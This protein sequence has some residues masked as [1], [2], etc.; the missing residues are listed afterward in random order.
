MDT[1]VDWRTWRGLFAARSG[2][3]LPTLHD[4]HDY[5]GVPDSVARSL[6]IF[7]LGESG[8][9]TVVTQARNSRI[10]SAGEDYG[11]AMRLFVAEEHPDGFRR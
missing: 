7:Q 5:S 8:G 6:A 4:P 9:G 2:R 1:K 3:G 10:Q 11:E